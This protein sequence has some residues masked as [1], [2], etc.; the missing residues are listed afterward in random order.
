MAAMEIVLPVGMAEALPGK[1]AGAGE[2]SAAVR[3]SVLGGGIDS[4]LRDPD[5]PPGRVSAGTMARKEGTTGG[6][7]ALVGGRNRQ[8]NSGARYR[9][10]RERAT[11][12]CSEITAAAEIHTSP[13][14]PITAP[15]HSGDRGRW[16]R[17][18]EI[19]GSRI[20]EVREEKGHPARLRQVDHGAKRPASRQ[21]ACRRNAGLHSDEDLHPGMIHRGSTDSRRT[22]LGR[23]RQSLR[24]RI[25]RKR[26]AEGT[27]PA[28]IR[29]RDRIADDG[30][31]TYVR[32]SHLCKRWLLI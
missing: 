28:G 13:I 5:Q 15:A 31:E 3:E 14:R 8:G 11:D 18:R 12:G 2:A 16:S 24:L 19:T 20:S 27:R 6:S 10:R 4:H 29:G 9:K 7:S 17:R 21:R 22:R 23:R 30:I 1:A 25:T 26:T 32:K